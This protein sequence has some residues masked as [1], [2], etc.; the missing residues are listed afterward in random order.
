M[1]KKIKQRENHS[2][3][4]SIAF[5]TIVGS[6]SVTAPA[7]DRSLLMK[8]RHWT[9]AYWQKHHRLLLDVVDQL[10]V[11][12]LF[13]TIAP[14]EWSLP[15]PHWI[16]RCME[17]TN[18]GPTD[19]AGPEVLAVA[20]LLHQICAGLLCGVTS[21][22]KW[23]QHLLGDKTKREKCVEAY[24][25]RFEFQDG[26]TTHQFGKG[27]GS[28]HVHMVVWMRV[29]PQSL[30]ERELCAD[31]QDCS[32][33]L[34]TIA[35]QVQCSGQ[36]ANLE[37]RTEPSAWRFDAI[38][39]KWKLLLRCSA[40]F[41]NINC[42]PFLKT[43]LGVLRCHQDVQWSQG[44]GLLLRYVSGYVSKFGEAWNDDWV[45][46]AEG[47]L[48][49]ALHVLR[50]WKPSEAQMVMTL[51]REQMAFSNVTSIEYRPTAFEK[52]I[53]ETLVLYRRRSD[54]EKELS[55]LEWLRR[56]VVSKSADGFLTCHDR[57]TSGVT[58]VAVHYYRFPKAEFFWQWLVMSVPHRCFNELVSENCN[59]V[60]PH[61]RHFCSAWE[62]RRS[63]WAN[64]VWIQTWLR[65]Q[66]E[67]EDFVQSSLRQIEAMRV[68]CSRQIM[69]FV[70]KYSVTQITHTDTEAL[71]LT[72]QRIVDTVWDDM[73]VR[74]SA[75]APHR[76]KPLF[77]TGGPGTGKTVAVKHAMLKLLSEDKRVLIASPTG[78]LA[79]SVP[80]RSNAVSTTVNRA[81]GLDLNNVEGCADFAATFD[82]WF[83]F[84]I[85]MLTQSQVEFILKSWRILNRAPVLVFDGDFQQL[86]PADGLGTDARD[87][88]L[89]D[90]RQFTLLQV[91]R[92]SDSEL[93]DFQSSVRHS[94]PTDKQVQKFFASRLVADEITED[95]LF[96]AWN[97]LPTAIALVGTRRTCDE[98]NNIALNFF[99]DDS[100][101][102]VPVW[103]NDHIQK[104][105]LRRNCRVMITRNLDLDS[106]V[107]NGLEGT[108]L[109]VCSAGVIVETPVGI[110]IVHR[111]TAHI[112]TRLESAFDLMLGYAM[113]VHKAQGATIPAV[114][115]IFEKW[116]CPGW[117]YT[118]VSRVRRK[119]DLL[120]IGMPCGLHFEPR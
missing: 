71:S 67:R 1:Y 62:I 42:R 2:M 19:M 56:K 81:F 39:Q 12:D 105:S 119:S 15:F 34:E 90:V 21:G 115:L 74:E 4:S 106:G 3:Q 29:M 50:C 45:N 80:N 102:T 78:R 109:E 116:C 72:Q 53:D 108:V 26:G 112:G 98:V 76:W 95:A 16:Q 46:S 63:C 10:G 117:G 22:K 59:K 54:A 28:L 73:Q 9:C 91:F 8:H 25:A 86:P 17:L 97:Q 66:G 38:Q 5:R 43:V 51:A 79:C 82:A 58:A 37:E 75:N 20:H 118:A 120:A 32:S 49:A 40:E 68:L 83:V 101:G 85:S 94:R 41:L 89:W 93:L 57:R 14:Y 87:A 18:R 69:G 48:Q 7:T 70:P 55:F 113:T 44:S 103:H 13:V 24:F 88:E 33:D 104:L 6:G 92:T 65:N 47:S 96:D 64:D 36:P 30:L 111:R 11:P 61:L 31:F 52:P 60:S 23:T 107:C 27:R 100:L 110:R 114:I 35:R 77:V 99:G 84:E